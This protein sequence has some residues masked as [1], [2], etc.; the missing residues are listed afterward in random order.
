MEEIK[1]N[2]TDHL[3]LQYANYVYSCL[4]Y[5]NS[6]LYIPNQSQFIIVTFLYKFSDTNFPLH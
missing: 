6:S 2:V 3:R 1:H 4:T 5:H